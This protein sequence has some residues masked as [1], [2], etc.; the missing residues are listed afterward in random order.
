MLLY[1]VRSEWAKDRQPL[2]NTSQFAIRADVLFGLEISISM[3]DIR[4]EQLEIAC[5]CSERP[6]MVMEEGKMM[7]S[8]MGAYLLNSYFTAVSL[9]LDLEFPLNHIITQRNEQ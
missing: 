1:V 7:M 2:S 3:Q 8:L 4:W 9:Y 5:W 6:N